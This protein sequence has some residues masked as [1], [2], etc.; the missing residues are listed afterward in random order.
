MCKYYAAIRR[1]AQLAEG[2]TFIL[3]QMSSPFDYSGKKG[4][5]V[6]QKYPLDYEWTQG[7]GIDTSAYRDEWK[8]VNIITEVVSF[9]FSTSKNLF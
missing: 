7:V 6:K 8:G 1:A 2:G 3:P 9:D 4:F 5:S